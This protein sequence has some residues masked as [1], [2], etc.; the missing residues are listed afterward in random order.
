MLI[1]SQAYT[2]QKKTKCVLRLVSVIYLGNRGWWSGGDECWCDVFLYQ[3]NIC[4]HSSL[5]IPEQPCAELNQRVFSF[6]S[7]TLF[8]GPHCTSPQLMKP[9]Y[10]NSNNQFTSY[11]FSNTFHLIL[12]F[13]VWKLTCCLLVCTGSHPLTAAIDSAPHSQDRKLHKISMEI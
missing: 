6:M 9:F 13:G 10:S 4:A 5:S 2:Y 3:T 1:C 7:T 8:P 12:G 11:H